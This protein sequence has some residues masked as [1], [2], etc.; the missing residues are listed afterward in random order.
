MKIKDFDPWLQRDLGKQPIVLIYGPDTGLVHER[1]VLVARKAADNP[2]DPFQLVRLD[3]DEVAGDPLRLADEANTIAMFGGRRVI[4]VRAGSKQLQAALQ[5]L[6]A[7]PPTDA[8]VII[9]AGD[10]KGANPVRSACEKSGAAVVI[11]CYADE[12]AALLGLI[13]TVLGDAGLSINAGARQLL[14]AS[15][16]GDRAASRGEIEKLAMYCRGQKEV[17]EA[18]IEAIISD[19]GVLDPGSVIDG[20]FAGDFAPIELDGARLF[21]EGTDAGVLLNTALRHA[22]ALKRLIVNRTI[23]GDAFKAAAMQQGIYFKRHRV[24]EQQLRLWQL[25]RLERSI[26]QLSEAVLTVRR[27]ARI[28]EAIA[29]RALWAVA[30]GAKRK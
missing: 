6:L 23:S 10:L 4:W 5:P 11:A 30:L 1:A 15:L 13:Q 28:G 16:G 22:L 9:E 12:G 26:T 3:G 17:Q 19:V 27:N 2:D 8:I 29:T 18:D 21:A 24:V 7:A 14:L 20:A 25:D